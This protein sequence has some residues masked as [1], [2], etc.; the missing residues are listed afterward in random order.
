MIFKEA[1]FTVIAR[2]VLDDVNGALRNC[3][4]KNLTF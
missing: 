4:L 2:A 3:Y 1:T